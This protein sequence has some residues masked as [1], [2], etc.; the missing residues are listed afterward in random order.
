M[1][2]E[3]SQVRDAFGRRAWAQVRQGLDAVAVEERTVADL[4]RLAVVSYLVGEDGDAAAAWEQAHLRHVDAGDRAEAARCAFWAALCLML[5]G[6][7]ARAGGWLRRAQRLIGELDCPAAGYVEIPAM[8]AALDAGDGAAARDLAL[9]MGDVAD[10][11][12]ERDLKALSEAGLGQALVAMGDDAAGLA[13]LDEVMLSVSSGEVGPIASGIVYCAVLLVCMQCFDLARA[14]EWTEALDA[15]CATQPD[16][17]PYRGQCL[18]HQSQVQQAAGDWPAAVSTVA[19]ACDRLREPP[20]PALGLACYQE[21]ELD[22]LRGDLAAAADAYAQASRAGYSPFPGL[23]LLQLAR[24]EIETATSS[25]R[26]ALVDSFQ[27]FQRP[28]LLSAAVEVFVAGGD[29]AAATGCADELAEIASQSSSAV[30]GAI[31]EQAIGTVLLADGELRA[32]LAHLRGASDVWHRL[33]LPYEA[34]RSAVLLGRACLGL[35]DRSSAAL[36][37]DQAR[38]TFSSLG[39]ALDLL[40]LEEPT[41]ATPSAAGGLSAREIEVLEQVAHGRTNRE[42]ADALSI[43]HHTVG[44]HLENIFAKLGVSGRAAATAYAMEHGLL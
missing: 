14:S 6:Q 22:R 23:S 29:L 3:S 42:I 39:A 13:Q 15:W 31:A 37:L 1:A 16:L 20:H 36:E 28:P 17:V 27:P 35:G 24:G 40:A 12:D 41:G 10:R 34:A 2:A 38:A 44:R 30:L 18:V 9:R 8:L 11:F 5:Q 26:R 25:I 7:T 19:A 33:Q 32:A 43:S 21:G 4:E